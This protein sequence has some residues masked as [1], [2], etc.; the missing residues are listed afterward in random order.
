MLLFVIRAWAVNGGS[1]RGGRADLGLLGLVTSGREPEAGA[2]RHRRSNPLGLVDSRAGGERD[3]VPTPG[4]VI[5]RRQTQSSRATSRDPPVPACARVAVLPADRSKGGRIAGAKLGGTK[6]PVGA[7]C[8][9][10]H[11]AA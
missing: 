4:A 9:G 6:A 2:D 8:W 10:F 3:D 11:Q 5:S 7:L 1:R